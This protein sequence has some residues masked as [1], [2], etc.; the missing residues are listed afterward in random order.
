MEIIY[1]L[2]PLSIVLLVI[3]I[4][5]FIWAVNSGQFDDMDTPAWRILV[6]D[7]RVDE[8]QDDGKR[9][10]NEQHDDDLSSRE[11]KQ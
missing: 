3:A 1:V 9:I 6:D 4:A 8:K 5:L 11:E 10:D 2:I 7:K